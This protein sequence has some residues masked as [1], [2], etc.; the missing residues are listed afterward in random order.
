MNLAETPKNIREMLK[1]KKCEYCGKEI[2][3]HEQYCSDDCHICANNYYE[4]SQKFTKLF[5]AVSMACVI[6]IPVGLFLFSF[7]KL[8]G[9]LIASISAEALGFL[10]ILIPIPTEGMIKKHKIKAA[11]RRTRIFGI[12]VLA[13]GV[14]IFGLLLVFAK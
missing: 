12:F 3:Y 1:M 11:V 7:L 6:G 2:S 8:M 4:R 13:L 10:L 9:V 5:Y 14:L